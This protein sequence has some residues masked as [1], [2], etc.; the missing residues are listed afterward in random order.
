MPPWAT[1]AT[2]SA[3][4]RRARRI[5]SARRRQNRDAERPQYRD[6]LQD[7]RRRRRSQHRCQDVS[8]GASPFGRGHEA[9]F[10][11]AQGCYLEPGA[12]PGI[13]ADPSYAVSY[14]SY[15]VVHEE[16]QLGVILAHKAVEKCS[17]IVPLYQR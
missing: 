4:R 16:H 14:A 5:S 3:T 11:Q 17:Q 8:D 6:R 12:E 7:D 2:P 9:V 13:Y 1:A 10:G 15:D